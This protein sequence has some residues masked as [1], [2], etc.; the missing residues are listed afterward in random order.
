MTLIAV[1]FGSYVVGRQSGRKEGIRTAS[2]EWQAHYAQLEKK[3]A[4]AEM[5]AAMIQK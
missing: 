2:D 3:R 1:S 4:I 5:K